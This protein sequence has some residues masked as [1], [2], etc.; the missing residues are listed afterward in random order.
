MGKS[1]VTGRT[2]FAGALAR[3]NALRAALKEPCGAKP[4][5]IGRFER[6]I[7]LSTQNICESGCRTRR[8]RTVHETHPQLDGDVRPWW[9]EHR[10]VPGVCGPAGSFNALLR[11]RM[12]NQWAS[13]IASVWPQPSWFARDRMAGWGLAFLQ[14]CRARR[15]PAPQRWWRSESGGFVH[16]EVGDRAQHPPTML[17]VE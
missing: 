4:K 17:E 3:R 10:R 6:S 9:Q 14:D 16:D 5:T 11:H 1:Y 12:R 2:W 15:P 8:P 13:V 7:G